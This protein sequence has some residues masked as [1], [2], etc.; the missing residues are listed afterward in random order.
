M[1]LVARTTRLLL[2]LGVIAPAAIIVA[3]PLSGA[4]TAR[5]A[6]AVTFSRDIAPIIFQQ[7][8]SCHRPGEAAPFSLLTYEDASQHARQVA[9]V[10]K[11][12]YMPPWKAEPGYGEFAGARR[13][14]DQQIALI[15][16][17][18]DQGAVAGDPR[19]LPPPPQWQSGWQLGKPD[20]VITMPEPYLLKSGGSDVFRSF[21]IPIPESARRY[22]KGVEFRPGTPKAIHHENIKIDPTQS[23]R[24]HDDEDPEPGFDGSAG[25]SAR[26]PDG[27]FMGW[28]PGKVPRMLPD[29]MAWRLEPGSDLVVELHMVPTGKPEAIQVSVGLFFTDQPPS[30]VPS[31]LRLGR[32]N[33]DIP[34]GEREYV[35]T[36]AYVLPVEVEVLEVYPHAHY[37]AKEVSGFARLPDGTTKWLI[38]IK[39][40]DFNWQDSYRYVEPMVLPRG[41]TLLMRYTYDNSADNPRNPSRPPKR[42][43]FGP[44]TS[45]EMGDLWIQVVPPSRIDLATLVRDSAPKML[46][47]DIAGRE[48]ALEVNPGDAR[49]HAEL[50]SYYLEVGRVADALARLEE[51]VRLEPNSATR[52]HDLGAVLLGQK[53]LEE[54]DR[55][56]S[57]AARLRP[58]FFEAHSNL[59][60]VRYLQGKLEDAIAAY[61][62]ALR[63]RPDSAETRYDLGRALA[64][65]GKSEEAIGE[66]RRVLQMR[67][68]DPETHSSL[69]SLLATHGQLDEGIAH[70]R[71]AL[72]LNPDLPAALVDLAWI[73]ATT[74]RLEIRAPSEAVRLA[75]RVAELT[76]YQ[77]A[78]VLDA[79]AV[80]YAASGQLDRAISTAQA[81]FALAS[82]AGA[83]ELAGQIRT[84]LE[85]YKQPVP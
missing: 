60:V 33:I 61:N 55:Q 79:L 12:R 2:L 49:L 4:Q 82:A 78:T 25:P 29:G 26:F 52:H 7:C 54:A 24:R 59:G 73:L 10:T 84:R 36:D 77:D 74:D 69:G 30:R 80:A 65:Q 32:Q 76:K 83:G 19:D 44:T 3:S 20:S 71:T 64:S 35:M 14:S 43:T 85:S 63:I 39:A 27:H 15:Q 6:T 45:S 31:M 41:T 81:A 47:E 40:W 5:S 28:T 68:D 11:N 50:A 37:L 75:E 48:K 51:A 70:L 67:R 53:R 56:F 72:E 58:N 1:V 16:Q 8:A 62:R 17:W 66:Y 46:R 9:L 57:E 34:A 21:V 23:S 22:V 38:Y 18:V 42:V 13:L